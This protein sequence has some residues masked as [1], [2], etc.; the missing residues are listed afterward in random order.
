MYTD[1]IRV[2]NGKVAIRRLSNP[3]LDELRPG[4]QIARDGSSVSYTSHGAS[5]T[6]SRQGNATLNIRLQGENTSLDA[7]TTGC[8]AVL[9]MYLG[10]Y[11]DMTVPDLEDLNTTS[12]DIHDSYFKNT[13]SSDYAHTWW[14]ADKCH[15]ACRT[16]NRILVGVSLLIPINFRRIPRKS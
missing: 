15:A 11:E 5:I 3:S 12:K 6:I 13:F 2:H 9:E 4:K 7:I 14:K 16:D 1:L 10:M 8:I